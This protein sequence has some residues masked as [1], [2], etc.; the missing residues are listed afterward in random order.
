LGAFIVLLDTRSDVD[1]IPLGSS[2]Q[3]VGEPWPGLR[4]H[5]PASFKGDEEVS[6]EA[7][8]GKV[9]P[10]SRFV[11]ASELPGM[12]FRSEEEE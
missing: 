12:T 9:E 1:V 2:G 6:G 4:R 7:R 5:T 8:I 10:E 11:V 3:P